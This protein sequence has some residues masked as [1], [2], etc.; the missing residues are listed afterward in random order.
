MVISN[1]KSRQINIY[2]YIGGVPSGSKRPYFCTY[3][4]LTVTLKAAYHHWS[5]F[6]MGSECQF[7]TLWMYPLIFT[8]YINLFLYL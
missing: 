4:E 2:I 7:K 1:W 3:Y 6:K 5:Y 8:E